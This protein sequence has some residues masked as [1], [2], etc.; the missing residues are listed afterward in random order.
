VTNN[1]TVGGTLGVT[2]ATSLSSLGVSGATTLAT[3]GTS[4]LATLNSLA[5]SNNASITGT[6]AVT[7]TST[8]TGNA[9]FTTLSSSGAATL[10]SS[11]V[12]NNQTIGGTLAV[13]GTSSYTGNAAFTT[14]STSGAATLN[15]ATIT[16]NASVGGTFAV[17]GT[18][19]HTGN[20]TFTT[21][22]TSGAATVNSSI[23]TN[24][25]TVGGTL[26]VTGNTALS[27]VS[28]SGA[29][30]LNSAAVTNNA[31]V[32]GTLA[33]TGNAGFTTLSSSGAATV[34]SSIVTNNES[35]GGILTVTG[36]AALSTVSSSGAATLNSLAVTNNATIGGTLAVTGNVTVPTQV[37][38]DIST[39]A[40]TTAF[41]A[42]Y[43]AAQ[44]PNLSMESVRDTVGG[45]IS[46]SIG[47]PRGDETGTNSSIA[48]STNLYYSA[49]SNTAAA[50]STSQIGLYNSSAW[51]LRTFSS[52]NLTGLFAA[53]STP[54]AGIEIWDVFVSW[55][56]SAVVGS[57][58]MWNTAA[59]ARASALTFQDGAY[60]LGSDP[61]KRY[62]GTVGRNA[63]G[64][65]DCNILRW[66]Y[67]Q[68]NQLSKPLAAPIYGSTAV[69]VVAINLG[70][71][72]IISPFSTSIVDLVVNPVVGYNSNA[73]AGQNY[74]MNIYLYYALNA[75]ANLLYVSSNNQVNEVANH[76]YNVVGQNCPGLAFG[77]GKY[78]FSV[79]AAASS[80]SAASYLGVSGSALVGTFRC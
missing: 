23:V 45:R 34:N 24:N 10:N 74:S 4:G 67:N 58:V 33:V 9:S 28:T 25:E 15:S 54:A 3:L 68:Y 38:T 56:G 26:A 19:A 71:V 18:S 76:Y 59:T 1:E 39:K 7:S 52:I 41:V 46:T 60:V 79:Q 48:Y 47:V 36:N 32:G 2:G 55:N 62:V 65:S 73:G 43:Y 50:T 5:V 69:G 66:I 35:V 13:T 31:T 61:T 29:A 57:V 78:T 21:L 16:N 12:T 11:I 77:T 63:S 49:L 75:G 44:I 64:F 6:L 17:T 30:T 27:T 70:A 14:A 80:A 51:S 72:S 20:S 53:Y 22:S 40:A 37:T 8:H 42:A